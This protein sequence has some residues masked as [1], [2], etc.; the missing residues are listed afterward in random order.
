MLF[1]SSTAQLAWNA[2][3]RIEVQRHVAGASPREASGSSGKLR[4]AFDAL[5][6]KGTTTERGAW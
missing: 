3:G 6:A 1:E 4:D 5:S 2:V